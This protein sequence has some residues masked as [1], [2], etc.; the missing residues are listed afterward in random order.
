MSG[1]LTL[2]ERHLA[3]ASTPENR[4]DL[5]KRGRKQL[6][7]AARPMLE[8]MVHGVAGVK[9]TT[10]HHDIRTVTG[11]EVVLFSLVAAP[12]FESHLFGQ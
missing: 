12:Q 7:E 11:E 5:I 10:M 2:D 1:G 8:S 4:R 3:K 9:V 6:L